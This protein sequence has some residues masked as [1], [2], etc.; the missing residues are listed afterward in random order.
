MLNRKLSAAFEAWQATAAQMATEAA[1]MHRAIKK[2]TNA[3]LAAAFETWRNWAM[4]S[5]ALEL[6][7][8]QAL[9]EMEQYWLESHFVSW[10][11]WKDAVLDGLN[12]V[13]Q[14]AHTAHVQP[15]RRIDTHCP[16]RNSR[17]GL[18]WIEAATKSPSHSPSSPMSP[19]ERE[20]ERMREEN[21]RLKEKLGLGSPG[22]ELDFMGAEPDDDA[23]TKALLRRA[24]GSPGAK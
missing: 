13:E 5:S 15:T 22:S 11:N 7:A 8:K 12:V 16:K 23:K 24:R 4:W 3:K 20:L 19:T 9:I 21:R 17:R 6:R 14:W 18:G 1:A 10:L 2:M